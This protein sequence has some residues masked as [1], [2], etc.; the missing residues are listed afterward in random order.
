MQQSF[1]V[2]WYNSRP[3]SIKPFT[4][5][6]ACDSSAKHGRCTQFP[7]K[8]IHVHKIRFEHF[9]QLNDANSITKWLFD[10]SKN[11]LNELQKTPMKFIQSDKMNQINKF[12]APTS[13][14]P[15][16]CS[17]RSLH[18]IKNIS[19]W[20]AE[21]TYKQIKCIYVL[22]GDTFGTVFR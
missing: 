12:K 4:H 20:K 13:R 15:D 11:E 21:I 2:D 17:H 16:D 19:I 3:L 5:S 18:F 7:L 22:S 8:N 9:Q 6:I 1:S 10:H 14:F